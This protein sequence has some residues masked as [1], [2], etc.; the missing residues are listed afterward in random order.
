MNHTNIV[1]PIISFFTGCHQ[2][3]MSYSCA[4]FS[5]SH[6]KV[7]YESLRNI[8]YSVWKYMLLFTYSEHFTTNGSIEIVHYTH[9]FQFFLSPVIFNRFIYLFHFQFTFRSFRSFRLSF[10]FVFWDGGW[11]F[12]SVLKSVISSLLLSCYHWTVQQAQGKRANC[13]ICHVS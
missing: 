3:N 9:T 5:T 12:F 8:F 10:A 6:L 4:Q 7:S 2:S 13:Q 11:G 1:N